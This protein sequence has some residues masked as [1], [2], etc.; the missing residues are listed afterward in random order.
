MPEAAMTPKSS[1]ETPPMTGVG[2]L[3][4]S[5]ASLPRHESRM[6]KT[7][8]PPMTQVEKTFVMASTPM[9][10]PYVVFGVEPKKPE[11]MVERPLP[12]MER[13]RP[14]SFVRSWPTMLPVTIRWLM[15]S[16]MTTREA[17]RMM[18]MAPRSNFGV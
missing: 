14:G 17:G 12:K 13:S 3:W 2:M 8:A 16:T 15:C 10:S 7:A 11:M 6:A 9:F 1:M 18:R 4:I 5:A